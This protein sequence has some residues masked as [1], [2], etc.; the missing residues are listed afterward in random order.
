MSDVVLKIE[1]LTKVIK[2][3][4]ILHAIDLEVQFT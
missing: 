2:Q 3:T 4:K 1:G